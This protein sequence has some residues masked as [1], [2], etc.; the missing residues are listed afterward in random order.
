[1]IGGEAAR[2]YLEEAD[3]KAVPN[4]DFVTGPNNWAGQVDWVPEVKYKLVCKWLY[5]GELFILA[6]GG[7]A[8]CC[9]DA[10][11]QSVTHNVLEHKPEDVDLRPFV[12]CESCHHDRI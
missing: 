4:R 12:L 10:F 11:G 3:V 8:S 9:I 7:V 1:M 6:D 5:A 2:R